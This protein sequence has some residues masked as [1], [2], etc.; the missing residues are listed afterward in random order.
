MQEEEEEAK[1]QLAE[2]CKI[3][4]GQKKTSTKTNAERKRKK[5][6]KLDE[7]EEEDLEEV[8]DIDKDPNYNPDD[9][10]EEVES[11]ISEYPDIIEVEKHAHC[12]NLADAGEFCVWIREQLVELERHVKIGGEVAE[13]AYEKFVE[14]LRDG[15]FKMKTWSPIEAASVKQVMKTV[16]DPTC[17]AWKK[18][19]KGVKTGN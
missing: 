8:D 18:K 17:T 9:D 15:I 13:E 11:L 7:D 5:R 6:R 10:F 3:K 2:L 19:M 12:I 14:M 16:V 1:K 4:R